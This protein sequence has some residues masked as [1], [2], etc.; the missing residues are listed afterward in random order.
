MERLEVEDAWCPEVL[1]AAL[2]RYRKLTPF[3]VS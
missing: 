2:A 1:A 3:N